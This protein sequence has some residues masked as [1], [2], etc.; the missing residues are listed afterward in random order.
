MARFVK[1][2]AAG[3]GGEASAA[4]THAYSEEDLELLTLS[5]RGGGGVRPVALETVRDA[6]GKSTR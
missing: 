1:L 4:S 6:L 2:A 5:L 3:H